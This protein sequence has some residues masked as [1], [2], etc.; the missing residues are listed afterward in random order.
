M[1]EGAQTAGNVASNRL[2]R[3]WNELLQELRV[4]QTGVQI[5][6]GFLLTIP[7]SARFTDLDET[8]QRVYLGVLAGAV[9]ATGFLVAP[10]AFHRSLFYYGERPWLI[11]AA[12]RTARVGLAT[13]AATICGVVWLVFSVVA[14]DLVASIAAAVAAV[15]FLL[16]WGFVPF[17][18]SNRRPMGR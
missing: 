15:F 7:F 17:A 10:V 16:L 1:S 4:A 12:N 6:T 2:D 14:N 8:T 13:L 5:L 3:K 11:A 9:L 18:G